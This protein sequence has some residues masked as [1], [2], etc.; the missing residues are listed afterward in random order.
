MKGFGIYIKN[1]LLDPKHVETMGKAVWLYMWLIDHMTSINED[2]I[3]RVLGGRPVKY[4]EIRKDLGI[5]SGVYTEWITKLEAYPYIKTIRTPYGIVF[6]V[7]KAEKRFKMSIKEIQEKAEQIQAKAGIHRFRQNPES[8]K[9][10]HNKTE[11]SREPD[12][13]EVFWKEYPKRKRDRELCSKK[14]LSFPED[15]QRAIVRDVI[16]RK[17]KHTDWVKENG[18]FVCAPI[19][20]LRGQRWEEEIDGSGLQRISNVHHNITNGG[21]SAVEKV[22]EKMEK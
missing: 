7:F 15:L 16:N 9:T 3:G 13:F 8:N 5:T 20:Y 22:R 4:P 14:F 10:I 6:Y 1:D 12:L 18:R 17:A 2:G 11:D 19:V 21:K